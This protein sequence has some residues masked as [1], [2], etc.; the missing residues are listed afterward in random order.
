MLNFRVND[1]LRSPP[2]L[3]HLGRNNSSRKEDARTRNEVHF[4]LIETPKR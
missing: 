3:I 2:N 4:Q 1:P